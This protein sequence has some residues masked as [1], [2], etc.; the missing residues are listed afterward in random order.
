[1]RT[2]FV[3]SAF[4]LLLVS[5]SSVESLK[6]PVESLTTDWENTTTMV[7]DFVDNLQATQ[8][9][10][11]N[12]FAEMTVP[13]GLTLSEESENQVSELKEDYQEEMGSIT[14]LS[15]EVSS[16]IGDWQAQAEKLT[17]LK[18]GLESSALGADAMTTVQD[19]QAMVAAGKEDLEGWQGELADIRENTADM[20][21]QFHTLM[22]NLQGN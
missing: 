21:E 4:A 8:Q 20:A 15:G 6:E 3:M 9:E 10:L 16:F 18:T 14:E 22:A 12:Q 11:Q 7:T 13:E 19:L 1:M 2:L 5:C 17:E